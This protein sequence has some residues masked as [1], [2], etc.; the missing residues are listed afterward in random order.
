MIPTLAPAADDGWFTQA[1]ATKGH[2]LFNNI[3]AQCH[4]PTLQGGAGPAL[5][6]D[7]FLAKWSNQPLS[8]LYTFEHAKMPAINPG[9]VPPDQLWLITAW[10][11]SKNGFSAGSTEIGDPALNRVLKK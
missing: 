8:A 3:C 11:L 6:G 10:I 5:V 9:S 2:Q 4:G 7:A 1:Q